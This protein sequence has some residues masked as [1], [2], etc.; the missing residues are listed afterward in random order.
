MIKFQVPKVLFKIIFLMWMKILK[1]KNVEINFP[2]VFSCP[3]SSYIC[4]WPF[5][6]GEDGTVKF[7][8]DNIWLV[9]KQNQW[10]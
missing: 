8:T 9:K 1:I 6:D 5:F 7:F 2:I 10:Y 4:L 3:V